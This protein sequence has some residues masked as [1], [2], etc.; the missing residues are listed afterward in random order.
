MTVFQRFRSGT[1]TPR[2]RTSREYMPEIFDPGILWDEYGYRGNVLNISSSIL[3]G[4]HWFPDDQDFNQ[5]TG[6]DSK[7]LM[8]VCPPF[9]TYKWL[10]LI[11]NPGAIAGHVPPKMVQCLSVFME[12]CYI[13]CKNIITSVKLQHFDQ[14]LSHFYEYCTVFIEKGVRMDLSLPHQHS[15]IHYADGIQMFGSL[16]GLDSSITESKHIKA[17]KEPWRCSSQ[18]EPLP[19]MMRTISRLDK[20]AVL[21]QKFKERGML[22]GTIAWYTCAL[23]SG[24]LPE[25]SHTHDLDDDK[26]D[27]GPSRGPPICSSVVLAVEYACGWSRNIHNVAA[28]LQEPRLPDALYQFLH[29]QWHPTLALSSLGELWNYFKF[30]NGS[31]CV[32]YSAVVRYYS[33][34]DPCGDGGMHCERIRSHPNWLRL[35]PHH[36]TALVAIDESKPGIAGMVVGRVKLFFSVDFEEKSYSCALMEWFTLSMDEPDEETGF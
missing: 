35:Y 8:K 17:V 9:F 12:V 7:V 33:P 15:L 26:V 21:C 10:G 13:A 25:I 2:T 27:C 5:W 18:N 24:T 23:N 16:N 4:I 11:T 19:Q 1:L 14:H 6:D 3:P 30:F 32:Y 31:I 20:M 29:A 36:D 22:Q 34:S 28:T